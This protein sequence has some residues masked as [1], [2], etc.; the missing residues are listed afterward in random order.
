MKF[1]IHEQNLELVWTCLNGG[2]REV[3]L[4]GDGMVFS[5]YEFD[6]K[7]PYV[8]DQSEIHSKNYNKGKESASYRIKLSKKDF[9]PSPSLGDIEMLLLRAKQIEERQKEQSNQN[10]NMHINSVRTGDTSFRNDVHEPAGNI[11]YSQFN[12]ANAEK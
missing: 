8:Q 2:Q 1:N 12:K 7:N 5:V 10:P 11:D 3:W 6:S 4:H 9:N